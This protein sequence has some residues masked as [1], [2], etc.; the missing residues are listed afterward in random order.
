MEDLG[1]EVDEY[2]TKKYPLKTKKLLRHQCGGA[3]ANSR[4]VT[5]LDVLTEFDKYVGSEFSVT[6]FK[7]Y[8]QQR[9]NAEN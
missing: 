5:A 7:L 1:K 2:F 4:Y 8:C 3:V 9:L 6:N